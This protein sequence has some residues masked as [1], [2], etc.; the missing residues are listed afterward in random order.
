MTIA[1]FLLIYLGALLVFVVYSGFVYYHLFR[2]G[3][4]SRVVYAVNALYALVACA[5]IAVS[6]A[7]ILQIDWTV[8]IF[9]SISLTLP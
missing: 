7:Y 9:P 2:F 5:L 6:L 1:V 4:K 8:P 3:F